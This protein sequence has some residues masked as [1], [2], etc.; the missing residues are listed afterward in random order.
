MSVNEIPIA[1]AR[2]DQRISIGAGSPVEPGVFLVRELTPLDATTVAVVLQSV[3]GGAD[4]E[5]TVDGAFTVGLV[6]EP[7]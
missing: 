3:D 1:D 7:E 2:V 6:S 4:V 5:A